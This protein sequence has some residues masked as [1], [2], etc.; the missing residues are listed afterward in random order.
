[1]AQMV[2]VRGS[3]APQF[4]EGGLGLVCSCLVYFANLYK[5]INF[6]LKPSI[7]P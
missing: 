2:G 5:L 3:G 7:L 4:T 6:L 1:M